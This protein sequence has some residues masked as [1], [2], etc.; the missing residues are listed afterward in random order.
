MIRKKDGKADDEALD[1]FEESWTFIGDDNDPELVKRIQKYDFRQAD[2]KAAT[3]NAGPLRNRAA[4][5]GAR[6]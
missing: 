1:D 2:G 5:R 6:G 4:S 3:L